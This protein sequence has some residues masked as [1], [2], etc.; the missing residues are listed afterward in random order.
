MGESEVYLFTKLEITWLLRWEIRTKEAQLEKGW[1]ISKVKFIPL[2]P[3]VLWSFLKYYKKAEQRWNIFIWFTNNNVIW[4]H[5][6]KKPKSDT[7]RLEVDF[8]TDTICK[9]YQSE[10]VMFDNKFL[11]QTATIVWP[12]KKHYSTL[13]LRMLHLL[14]LGLCMNTWTKVNIS[15]WGRRIEWRRWAGLQC[16]P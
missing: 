5:T 4:T 7:V 9:D 14:F 16:N 13:Y 15:M 8:V 1:W 12:G 10:M 6:L 3:Q 2:V 11:P